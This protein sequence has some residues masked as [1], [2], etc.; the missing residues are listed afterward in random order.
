M[1]TWILDNLAVSDISSKSHDKIF[2]TK[3][4]F[5]LDVRHLFAEVGMNWEINKYKLDRFTDG[6]VE[7]LNSGYDVLLYCFGGIDRSPFVAAVVIHKLKGISLEEAYNMVLEKRTEAF[8]HPEWIQA[9]RSTIT[10]DTF[11]SVDYMK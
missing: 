7:L 5:T 8:L 9:Y 11:K 6:V 4:D 2:R 10:L 1:I 3:I